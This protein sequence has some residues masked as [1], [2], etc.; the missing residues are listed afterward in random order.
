MRPS[1]KSEDPFLLESIQS[2]QG[3]NYLG[4]PKVVGG[5]LRHFLTRWIAY[6]ECD[7]SI[8]AIHNWLYLETEDWAKVFLGQSPEYTA[9][10]GWNTPGKIDH[11]I[12]TELHID[13]DFPDL[14]IKI[15]LA[16]FIARFV[17]IESLPTSGPDPE[18]ELKAAVGELIREATNEL[19]GVKATFPS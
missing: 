10:P 11:Y 8:P 2:A 6:R 17:S 19:M 12:K 18:G 5:I 14:V 3:P 15:Y 13:G 16:S 4:D 1:P 7:P 9:M